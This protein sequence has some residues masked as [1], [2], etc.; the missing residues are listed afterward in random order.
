MFNINLKNIRMGKGLS[1]KQIADFLNLSP[2]SISKWEKGEASPSIEDL[3]R[4]AEIFDCDINAFFVP[5]EANVYDLNLLKEF[6]SFMI[7]YICDE[8]K[9]SKDFLPFWK[10]HPDI[11]EVIRGL[12]DNIKQ[13]QT[14][15]IKTIQGILNCSDYDAVIFLDYFIKLEFIEKIE[16][17]ESYFVIKK[18]IC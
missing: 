9:K 13:H 1:Q 12:C 4:L 15:K 16:A 14:V 5:I 10:E 8:S 17:D 18:S 7:K 11:L 3:P 6:F 2:Q